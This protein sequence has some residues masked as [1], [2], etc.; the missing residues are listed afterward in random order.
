MFYEQQGTKHSQQLAMLVT[1]ALDC[2]SIHHLA[3]LAAAVQPFTGKCF[4][5]AKRVRLLCTQPRS[6]AGEELSQISFLIKL[7]NLAATGSIL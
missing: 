4:I 2:L 3:R 6:T 7:S 1:P 5:F